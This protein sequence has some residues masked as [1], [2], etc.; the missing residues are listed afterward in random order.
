M[1]IIAFYLPQYHPTEDNNKWWG[2]GFTEWTN[3]AKAQKLYPGHYQP[4]IPADLGF[5]DLRLAEVREQQSQMAKEAGV[6]GFCYY[7]YWF[8][9]G[10]L[11]LQLPFE[12]IISS[13]KPNFP[14]CLCWANESWGKKMWDKDGSIIKKEVLIEQ[15]YLGEEDNILHFN[16][17]LKAFKD[18][19]Y[20]KIHD[21]LLFVIYKPLDFKNLRQF[22]SQW[23]GLALKHNLPGFYFVG[24]TCHIEKE[25][26]LLKNMGIDAVIACNIL[27]PL[28]TSNN[29]LYTKAKRFIKKRILGYPT[30][31]NYGKAINYFDSS[32]DQYSDVYP[33]LIPNWDHTPRSGSGG[34]LFE[35]STPCFFK[36]HAIQLIKNIHHKDLADQ[37]LFLKSWNEWGEGNYMEPDLKFGKGYVQALREAIN[38]TDVDM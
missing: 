31:I 13:G 2:T 6:T 7:H 22:M 14:I 4:H 30:V 36:K 5:Y 8:G 34:Y 25:Y 38:E 24:Y 15:E 17:L 20:M 3:V 12:E 28:S 1:E 33:T 29:A 18:P 23:Q 10:K 19:R 21:K 37:I 35:N 16:Y 27:K 32:Y 11:E 9:N 26:E